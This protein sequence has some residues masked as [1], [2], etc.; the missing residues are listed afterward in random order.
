MANKRNMKKRVDDYMEYLNGIRDELYTAESTV[1]RIRG[2]K[3]YEEM[4]NYFN[5]LRYRGYI[6]E[7]PTYQ[8]G[9]QVE[10]LKDIK[11]TSDSGKLLRMEEKIKKLEQE[12]RE[13]EERIKLQSENS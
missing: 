3:E 5:L 2:S 13:L 12:K 1:K 4:K 11:D 9:Y 7:N 6:K 10:F 8:N